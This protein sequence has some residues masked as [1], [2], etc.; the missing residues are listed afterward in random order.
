MTNI[1]L[2]GTGHMG[3]A[4]IR[5]AAGS[6]G[7]E[8]LR[9]FLSDVRPEAAEKLAASLLSPSFSPA[10]AD[11][12]SNEDVIRFS[13]LVFLAVKPQNME[14]LLTALRP[15]LSARKKGE[16]ERP[17]TLVSM[18]AGVTIESILSY[19]G[20]DFPVIRIM[21]NTPIDVGRGAIAYDTRNVSAEAVSLFTSLL[22]E[23]ALLVPVP[24]EKLDAVCA[25]SGCGPAFVYLM[26]RGMADAGESLGLSSEEALSLAAK[27]VEGAAGMVLADKGTPTELKNQVCS[28]GGATIEGVKVL[29]EKG[30]ESLVREALDASYRRTLE[31][32]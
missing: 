4:I 12:V 14:E 2:I 17:L 3:S 22:S 32:K 11:A 23:R 15:A 6:S 28:P 7:A 13:D 10:G 31:L 1:G 25:L 9:F 18:A 29:E 26:I 30:F 27:T 20:M 5:A 19:A 8:N 24:E 16:A 21:P